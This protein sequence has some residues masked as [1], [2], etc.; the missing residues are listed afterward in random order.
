MTEAEITKQAETGKAGMRENELAGM[1][2]DYEEIGRRLGKLCAEKNKA[3]GQ[4]FGDKSADF[5]R[6]LYPEGM[7]PDQY[8]NAL[9]L[10]RIFDK[11]GRIATDKDAFGENPF[12]DI[13]GYAILMSA[14]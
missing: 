10:V 11:Q 4:T 2:K 7:R 14:E 8:K 6:L 3:Y 1:G 12:A 5:L 13:A 9:V